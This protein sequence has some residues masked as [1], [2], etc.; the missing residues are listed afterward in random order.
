MV[1]IYFST[2]CVTW[3]NRPERLTKSEVRQSV[4]ASW[5]PALLSSSERAATITLM[6]IWRRTC[7]SVPLYSL[8]GSKEGVIATGM[9]ETLA[10]PNFGLK[11]VDEANS[12]LT[13]GVSDFGLAGVFV[14]PILLALTINVLIRL[15]LSRAS[16]L[17]RCLVTMMCV[18]TLYQTESGFANI[19]GFARNAFLLVLFWIPISVVARFFMKQ[20][21]SM[22]VQPAKT[23]VYHSG[24]TLV[25]YQ[26]PKMR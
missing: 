24:A 26:L 14:Y 2:Q 8:F 7:E 15:G 18:F 17:M 3:Q 12:Y 13:G 10:N 25:R 5:Y 20:N 11:A 16:E 22:T 1:P 23:K 4:W 6:K 19:I 9:E 21:S